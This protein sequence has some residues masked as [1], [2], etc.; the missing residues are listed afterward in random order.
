MD[1]FL[2][3]HL[4]SRPGETWDQ[5]GRVVVRYVL[6]SADLDSWLAAQSRQLAQFNHLAS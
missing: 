5:Y 1:W 4:Q 6:Q 3:G 2:H